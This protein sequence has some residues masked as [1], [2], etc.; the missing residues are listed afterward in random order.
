MSANRSGTAVEMRMLK[1]LYQIFAE[2][3]EGAC[4]PQAEAG[5]LLPAPATGR[6]CWHGNQ[7]RGHV[8]S[9]LLAFRAGAPVRDCFKL[10]AN[11]GQE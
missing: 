8:S 11:T 3:E 10:S 9:P 4:C 6:S 7:A 2:S 1:V 5:I